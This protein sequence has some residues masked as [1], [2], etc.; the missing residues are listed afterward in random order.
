ML[1][2]NNEKIKTFKEDM[3]DLLNE[4]YKKLDV[5]EGNRFKD[6]AKM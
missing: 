2:L 4:Y 1:V 6:Q 5:A 3:P